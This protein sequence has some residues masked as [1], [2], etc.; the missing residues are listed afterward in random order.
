MKKSTKRARRST[1][2]GE[3]VAAVCDA[4]FQVCRNERTAYQLAAVALEELLRT[5]RVTRPAIWLR[6]P[7]VV[8]IANN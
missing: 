5:R 7:V 8:P 4:A 3:L 2:F 1:T 6:Q